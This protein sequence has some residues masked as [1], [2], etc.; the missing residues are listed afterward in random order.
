MSNWR[1]EFEVKTTIKQI[2]EAIKYKEAEKGVRDVL[3]EV[4]KG[5]YSIKKVRKKDYSSFIACC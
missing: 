1:D 4:I 3:S 5:K 2:K